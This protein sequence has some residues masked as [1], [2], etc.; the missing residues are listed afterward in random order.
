MKITN[1][2]VRFLLAL[3]A[4]RTYEIAVARSGKPANRH[5]T[6]KQKERRTIRNKMAKASR[7]ANRGRRHA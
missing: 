5:L 3:Q 1:K 6:A 4:G 7:K 2:K